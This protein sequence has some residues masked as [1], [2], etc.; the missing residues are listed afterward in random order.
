MGILVGKDTR[1]VVQGITAKAS[2]H[3]EQMLEYG[4]NIVAGVTQGSGG[5]GFKTPC[6]STTASPTPSSEA[7]PTP[8]SSSCRRRSP[9][10]R[11]S[12][13]RRRHRAGRLHHRGRARPR[14]RR[15]VRYI[16]A[17]G[18]TCRLIGPNCP[19]AD[20][21]KARSGSCR[22][23]PPPA[24]RRGLPQRHAHLRGGGPAHRGWAWAVTTRR[25]RRRPDHRHDVRRS[26]RDAPGRPRPRR[27]PDRR[28]RR[29]G[30]GRRRV[31]Q[32][33]TSRSRSSLHR[34]AT[35]PEGK[36]MGHAGAIIPTMT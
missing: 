20:S 21:R 35:A 33:A 34:R 17:L 25:R 16:D 27:C 13:R 12:R 18:G 8:G 19:G 5:D 32:G 23:H 3:A 2:S 29:H 31:H 24:R 14:Y 7:A 6:R 15:A 30:R 4:T 11:S 9:A 22:Q 1:L 26:P 28:D 36:R 10:T